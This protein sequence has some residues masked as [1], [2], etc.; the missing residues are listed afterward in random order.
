MATTNKPPAKPRPE[1][2][3]RR[4]E[5]LRIAAQ[6]FAERGFAAST[7]REIAE[8]ASTLSGSLYYYFPSKESMAFEVVKRYLEALMTR[9][10]EIAESEDSPAVKIHHLIEASIELSAQHHDEVMI[11]F[12]DWPLLTGIDPNLS[13][14][15]SEIENLWVDVLEAGVATD[16]FRAEID[17]RLA[18]RTIMGAVAWV[19]RWFRASGPAPIAEVARTQADI[20][21]GGLVRPGRR[22]APR[23][24]P[25]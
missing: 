14:R 22:R 17:S 2:E 25:R 13:T 7:T 1:N 9:Y 12:Q 3:D 11:L 23:A 15:M 10:R 4:E 18:Y 16:E 5:I 6:T 21:L 24:R 8:R 19:P 20:F